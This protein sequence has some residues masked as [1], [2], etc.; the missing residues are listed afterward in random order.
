LPSLL[1]DELGLV[2]A[3]IDLEQELTGKLMQDIVGHYNQPAI[4]SLHLDA[5][6]QGALQ[7][8]CREQEGAEAPGALDKSGLPEDFVVNNELPQ[9]IKVPQ[10]ALKGDRHYCCHCPGEKPLAWEPL[11]QHQGKE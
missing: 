10:D 7:Y 2:F 8:V 1:L 6:R 9:S 5:R 4:L 3:Q 11:G